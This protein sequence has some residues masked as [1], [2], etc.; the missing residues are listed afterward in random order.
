MFTDPAQDWLAANQRA[1]NVM[2]QLRGELDFETPRENVISALFKQLSVH[3]LD[4]R[5]AAWRCIGMVQAES[6]ARSGKL[7]AGMVEAENR[8]ISILREDG[9]PWEYEN[10]LGSWSEY[11][12][13]GV[14]AS[15]L[16]LE[17]IDLM[18]ALA[19]DHLLPVGHAAEHLSK[20]A[21]GGK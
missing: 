13:F 4:A 12:E 6:P 11:R 2:I 3:Y 8:T 1:R 14:W 7:I 9:R 18:D 20:A 10:F 21:A 5:Q 17:C 19:T 16:A 15:G